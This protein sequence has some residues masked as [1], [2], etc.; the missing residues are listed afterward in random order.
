MKKY[1]L[2]PWV[3]GCVVDGYLVLLDVR[4]DRYYMLD[5]AEWARLSPFL[6]TTPAVKNVV[7]GAD[8]K[9]ENSA[10]ASDELV[11]RLIAADLLAGNGKTGNSL[12][13]PNHCLPPTLFE[14]LETGD[15]PAILWHHVL[16][17][18][19]ASVLA[20]FWL[21]FWPFR[22][23]A[24]AIAD[25]N[26]TVEIDK[27]IIL[28]RVYDRLRPVMLRSRV[29]LYDSVA[30]LCFCRFYGYRPKIVFGVTVAPFAAH[31][32]VQIDSVILND[33]PANVADYHPIMTI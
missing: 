23:I 16:A 29:C 27:V 30:F 31:C 1:W 9:V 12:C 3:H 10:E 11:E 7:I 20:Y 21:K 19:V 32:W 2:N 18:F 17:A 26:G 13:P 4:Y 5:K 14:Q 15:E 8:A 24:S 6:A 22:K 28:A 33:Y 25:W